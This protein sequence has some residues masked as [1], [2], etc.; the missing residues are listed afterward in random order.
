[1]TMKQRQEAR[2]AREKESVLAL[3]SY[4]KTV[5]IGQTPRNEKKYFIRMRKKIYRA[6][7]RIRAASMLFPSLNKTRKT[8]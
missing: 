7:K 6:V 3:P 4:N 1:M 2:Y 5:E 8:P